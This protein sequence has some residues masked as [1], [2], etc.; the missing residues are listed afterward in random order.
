MRHLAIF[1]ASGH[2]KVVADIAE[3]LGWNKISFFD[4]V[5]PR[6]MVNGHWDVIG[7]MDDLLN[8]M[9]QYDGVFIAIG[10]N[11][12][13]Q[14]KT[15]MLLDMGVELPALIHPNAVVSRYV[16]LGEGTVIMPGV[17]VN[18]DTT[19]GNASILN[20]GCSID[21][22][23]NLGPYVHIS[24]GAKV[25]GGVKIGARS[26][27]GIGSSVR[28]MINIGTDAVIGAGAAVVADV[29]NGSTV[30]GVPAESL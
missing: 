22:D 27:V 1:G 5:W 2:G 13:R 19:I 30:V 24:P 18:A 23:C 14:F 20:T 21:H 7:N 16:S 9:S 12:I 26:W 8:S 25:A 10:D 28:Q 15:E 11:Q 29:K 17:V 4:D 6:K 3:S